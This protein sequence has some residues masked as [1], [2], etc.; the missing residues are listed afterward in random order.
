MQVERLNSGYEPLSPYFKQY[1][2]LTSRFE[3]KPGAYV[4]IEETGNTG[5]IMRSRR[6]SADLYMNVI[7]LCEPVPNLHPVYA[8]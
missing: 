5:H 2:H 4:V 6:M 7:L 8:F 1:K 3:L